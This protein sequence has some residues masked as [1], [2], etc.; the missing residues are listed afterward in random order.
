MSHHHHSGIRELLEDFMHVGVRAVLFLDSYHV[1]GRVI[2]INDDTVTLRRGAESV[3]FESNANGSLLE[4]S[5][6]ATVKISEITA[7]GLDQGP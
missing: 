7:V 3:E 2:S 4:N 1:E 5:D 6:Q